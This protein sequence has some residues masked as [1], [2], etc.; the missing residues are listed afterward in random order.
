MKINE[1]LKWL[2]F[3]LWPLLL[4]LFFTCLY[5]CGIK[6]SLVNLQKFKNIFGAILQIFGGSIVVLHLYK[7]IKTYKK[8]PFS[9]YLLILKSCPLSK[10]I[11]MPGRI[12]LKMPSIK[13]RANLSEIVHPLT[14]KEKIAKLQNQLDELHQSIDSTQEQN[15]KQL[16]MIKQNIDSMQN[17]S[18]KK[19]EELN[20]GIIVSLVDSFPFELLGLLFIIVGL[21]LPVV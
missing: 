17:E 9:N 1:F 8:N 5:I 4:I 13:F 6:N 14:Q 10:S 20:N 19:F 3:V 2:F 7:S 11:F 18:N 16:E 21:L 15:T 12:I